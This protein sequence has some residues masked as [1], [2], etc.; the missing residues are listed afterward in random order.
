[1]NLMIKKIKKIIKDIIDTAPGLF[2]DDQL[3]PN[4]QNFQNTTDNAFNLSPQ[5]QQQLNETVFKK[6]IKQPIIQ[7][8]PPEIIP[9]TDLKTEDFFIEGD[10]F[11]SFKK[12]E[13]KL[14]IGQLKYENDDLVMI[15]DDDEAEISK[16]LIK[17]EID[18]KSKNN[19]KWKKK[20]KTENDT[21]NG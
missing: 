1:M 4:E 8:T 15:S 12:P 19:L 17:T 10:D 5:V 3:K 11:D 2:I 18:I 16:W 7:P 13:R 20:T 21:K 6:T 9:N 14:E